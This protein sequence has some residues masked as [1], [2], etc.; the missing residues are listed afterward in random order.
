M[1][2]TL[3]SSTRG[4]DVGFTV[5]RS[6]P[7]ELASAFERHGALYRLGVRLHEEPD[8]ASIL[9][10]LAEGLTA[11]RLTGFMGR[12]TAERASVQIS[13]IRLLADMSPSTA[14]APVRPDIL[15]SSSA[16]LTRVLGG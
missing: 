3:D 11:L 5:P 8:Q 6:N 1:L 4:Q 7:A 14:T 2:T 12:F 9:G 10:V 13:S 15:L 16:L